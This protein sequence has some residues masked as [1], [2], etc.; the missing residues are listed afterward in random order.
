METNLSTPTREARAS[1]TGRSVLV[2]VVATLLVP[3][4][5][6]LSSADRGP[7]RRTQSVQYEY[8]DV[9]NVARVP[10]LYRRFQLEASEF[11]ERLDLASAIDP[12]LQADCVEQVV[13]VAV[14]TIDAPVLTAHHQAR[15]AS[16]PVT[17]VAGVG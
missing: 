5:A 3:L 9:T 8:R 14:R 10:A 7:E 15:Q 4:A 6:H 2:L 1:V 12:Q 13:D 11:C 17:R 16:A